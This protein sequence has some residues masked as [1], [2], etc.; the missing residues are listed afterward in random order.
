MLHTVRGV[1]YLA[2]ELEVACHLQLFIY[3]LTLAAPSCS[4]TPRNI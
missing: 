3:Q 2:D 4:I 1:G